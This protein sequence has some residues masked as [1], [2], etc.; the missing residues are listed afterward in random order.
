MAHIEKYTIGAVGHMFKHYERAKDDKGEYIKFGNQA[1]D[2]K[3]TF[4][5][6]NM[7][8]EQKLSEISGLNKRIM[9]Y[10]DRNNSL[11]RDRKKFSADL[12]LI[13]AVLAENPPL[14]AEYLRALKQYLKE[15]PELQNQMEMD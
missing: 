14:N 1:I 4:S 2:L 11:S 7:A 6:Y 8:T 13:K 15:H 10:Y 12:S 5:N 9:E 3:K